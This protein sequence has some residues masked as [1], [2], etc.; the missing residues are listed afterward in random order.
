MNLNHTLAS[1]PQQRNGCLAAET[2]LDGLN[3]TARALLEAGVK[4]AE[5]AGK[6]SG[7]I[8]AAER[9]TGRKIAFSNGRADGRWFQFGGQF[10]TQYV[11]V[12]MPN[13]VRLLSARIAGVVMSAN[14]YKPGVYDHG[15]SHVANVLRELADIIEKAPVPL[16]D[17]DIELSVSR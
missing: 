11:R 2:L 6:M 3:F 16:A 17:N 4:P 5:L 14:F 1:S 7:Q 9:A 12:S 13:A 15:N 10:G 8:V